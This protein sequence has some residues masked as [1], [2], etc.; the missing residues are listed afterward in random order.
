MTSKGEL[1]TS[2][3]AVLW[4]S[5]KP[6]T[7]RQVLTELSKSRDLA[8]TTVMTVMDR[9][10]RKG[11][12]SRQAQGRAYV[13]APVASQAAHTA[14]LLERVLHSSD[15]RSAALVSFV[16]RITAEDA[17]ALRSALAGLDEVP[18]HQGRGRAQRT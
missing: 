5:A 18:P 2:V 6:L 1:E 11:L 17:A 3:M 15:D 10:T 7:V 12:L 13:Y 8:Y 14:D 4:D 9:L 16:E